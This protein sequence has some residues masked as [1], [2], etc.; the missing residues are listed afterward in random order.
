MLLNSYNRLL[1]KIEIFG[2]KFPD[3]I[4]AYNFLVDMAADEYNT[5]A[6]LELTSIKELPM[7]K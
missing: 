1:D 2:Y 4:E 3:N 6:I 5:L 7:K